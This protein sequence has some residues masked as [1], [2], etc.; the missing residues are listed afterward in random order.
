MEKPDYYTSPQNNVKP[1]TVK[2]PSHPTTSHH[3]LPLDISA[4]NL[5]APTMVLQRLD[6]AEK[7]SMPS[8]FAKAGYNRNTSRA[9]LYG[10]Q[11]YGGGG[12]IRW[13]WLQGEGQIQNFLKHWRTDSQVSKILRTA[14]SWYQHNSTGVGFALFK[15][16]SIPIKYSDARYL[17]SLR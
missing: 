11:D 14:V 8:I 1:T 3:F 9:L 5:R 17:S 6:D 10:P 4:I 7:K 2:Q 12:F 13:K 15:K 16:P